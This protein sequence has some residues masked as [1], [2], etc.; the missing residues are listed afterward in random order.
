MRIISGLRIS[1]GPGF[2]EPEAY[3]I[4]GPLSRNNNTNLYVK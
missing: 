4:K 2:V 3:V 1:N